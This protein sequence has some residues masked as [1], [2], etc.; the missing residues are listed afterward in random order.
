MKKIIPIFI[1]ALFLF[2]CGNRGNAQVTKEKTEDELYYDSVLKVSANQQVAQKDS[3]SLELQQKID[4]LVSNLS[5]YYSYYKVSKYHFQQANE[6]LKLDKYN[7]YA[8]NIIVNYYS[9]YQNDSVTIFFDNLIANNKNEIEPFLLRDYFASHRNEEKLN[10]FQ[11]IDNLNKALEIDVLNVTFNYNLGK[12]YYELFNTEYNKKNE[13]DLKNFAKNSI[14]YFKV[15]CNQQEEFKEILKYP[16]LQLA[17]YLNDKHNKDYFE[18]HNEQL[19]YFPVF[20]FAKLPKDWKTNYSVNVVDSYSYEYGF[21]GIDRALKSIN[22]YTDFLISCD[23]PALDEKLPDTYRF[24]LLRTFHNPIIVRLEKHRDSVKIYWKITDGKGGYG[25]GKM[26]VNETK[27]LSIEDWNNF[28]KL[29]DNTKFW[30][31]S[32]FD[33][34]EIGNDGSTWLIEGKKQGKYHLVERWCGGE[35][36]SLGKKLLELTDI[37]FDEKNRIY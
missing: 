23:E 25:L 3:L 9:K 15:V 10:H 37:K 8:I 26:F 31:L 35:I 2:S 22:Y 36:S 20:V 34:N 14:K 33:N 18:N 32:S 7:F 6:I 24:I 1:F 30:T 27:T 29:V 12:L 4:S 11:R 28:E 19:L 16:I 21:S 5:N 17:N 13:N